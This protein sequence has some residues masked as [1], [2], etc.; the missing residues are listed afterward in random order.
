MGLYP[1]PSF[2]TGFARNAS[3]SLFPSLWKDL[4][5]LWLPCLGVQGQRLFDVSGFRNDGDL[6]NMT[7]DD[8]VPGKDDGYALALDGSG[9]QIDC[10]DKSIFDITD[11][12]TVGSTFL[13][14][15]IN[16]DNMVLNKGNN[17]KGYYLEIRDFLGVV[18]LVW[19]YDNVRNGTNNDAIVSPPGSVLLNTWATFHGNYSASQQKMQLFKDGI[20]SAEAGATGSA[21]SPTGLNLRFGIWF[22]GSSFPFTGLIAGTHI[23]NRIL[24]E[25][26]MLL[27]ASFPYAPLILKDDLMAF[28]VA[29]RLSRYHDLSGI[30]SQGQMTWN[31]LG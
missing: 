1:V 2:A 21:A 7:N 10:G 19:R 23:Y 14:T 16:A 26:E 6:L 31:P 27:L 25:Q 29:G 3:Q 24:L 15:V 13:P 22:N 9:D 5:G 18:D 30:G 11:E 28:L 4:K 8:W 12:I 17:A 20:L